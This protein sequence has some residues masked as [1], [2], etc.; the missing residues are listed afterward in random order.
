MDSEAAA[1]AAAAPAAVV[2]GGRCLVGPAIPRPVASPQSRRLFHRALEDSCAA[3]AV[4]KR[5]PP[6]RLPKAR[7]ART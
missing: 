2:R 5:M 7:L 4:D 1:W 3:G 6:G